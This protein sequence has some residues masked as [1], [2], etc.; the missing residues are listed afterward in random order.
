[1]AEVIAL[2]RV[3]VIPATKVNAL[4]PAPAVP[5]PIDNVKALC[6]SVPV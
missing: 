6:V 4:F 1:M 5:S 3:Y 2:A